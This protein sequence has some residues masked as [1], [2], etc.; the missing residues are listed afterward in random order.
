MFEL[1]N[2][3]D[4][5]WRRHPHQPREQGMR[6][7]KA[8]GKCRTPASM[9]EGIA[10]G[11]DEADDDSCYNYI[12]LEDEDGVKYRVWEG[13]ST[14]PSLSLSLSLLCKAWICTGDFNLKFML[15]DGTTL[16]YLSIILPFEWFIGLVVWFCFCLVKPSNLMALF[17]KFV[18]ANW[19]SF[20]LFDK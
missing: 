3:C 5:Y 18:M 20:C 8:Y 16:L 15:L 9:I 12:E 10:S 6:L 7:L 2:K 11:L 14:P 1:T 19:Y 17:M 13:S 4:L